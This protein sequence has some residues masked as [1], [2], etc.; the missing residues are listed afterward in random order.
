ML[1]AIA[2]TIVVY[3]VPPTEREDGSPFTVDDTAGY[4]IYNENDQF[5]K[6]VDRYSAMAE[7]VML[8]DRYHEYY[9]RTFDNDGRKS[10]PSNKFSI[11]EPK[12]NKPEVIQCD[13][14]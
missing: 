12:P 11:G 7:I 8:D 10:K 2:L 3:F 9:I 6:L 1:S 5:I 13:T 4:I 14:Y